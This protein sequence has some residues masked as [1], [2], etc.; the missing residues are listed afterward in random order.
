MKQKTKTKGELYSH[1]VRLKDA[2]EKI[3]TDDIAQM[4]RDGGVEPSVGLYCK[5]AT[6]SHARLRRIE[7]LVREAMLR[8]EEP[9]VRAA[10]KRV[11]EAVQ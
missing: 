5:H 9:E 4:K 10:M 8:S 2:E 6:L 7:A 3:V 11:L 1:T